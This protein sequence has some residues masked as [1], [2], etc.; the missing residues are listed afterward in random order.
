MRGSATA[1]RREDLERP[2]APEVPAAHGLLD[3][4][5]LLQL[6]DRAVTRRVTIISAPAGSGKTSLLLGLDLLELKQIPG[7]HPAVVAGGGSTANGRSS[8]SWP[9]TMQ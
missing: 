9:P 4:E 1:Q 3:R 8:F 5:R 2:I 6:L 7:G